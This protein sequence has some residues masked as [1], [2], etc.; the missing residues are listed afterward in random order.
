MIRFHN[1][2]VKTYPHKS[3]DISK[4]VVRSKELSLCIIEEIK[5]EMRKQGVIE[6]KRVS[7]KREWKIIEMNTYIMTFD[8]TKIIEM[9]T[10][11]MTFD[12]TKIPEKMKIGYTMERVEQ[13]LPNPLQCFNCQ[14][15]SHYEDN[16]RDRQVCGKYDQQDP[17]HHSDKCNYSYNC[18]NSGGDHLIYARSCKSWR[19]ESE[20]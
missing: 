13:F 18:A 5:S 19:L 14:K 9:N 3:L 4:G 10:Y 6:V 8:Q 2:T 11:I 1:I 7:I 15:Y 17:D 20:I 12:Q 16:C